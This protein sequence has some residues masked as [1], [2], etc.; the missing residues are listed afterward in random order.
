MPL[1]VYFATFLP[2]FFYA[3]KPVNP[4]HIIEYQGYI[5]KLQQSVVKHH[6]YQS[7]WWQWVI[8][9]RSIWFLYENVDGAQRG[10]VMLGNPLA[11]WAGLP[12]VLWCLWAGIW[13]KRRDA[14]AAAL[15][16]LVSIGMW[17][18]NGKPI[19]FYY[20][21]LL[22]GAFLMACLALA[23]DSLW[24]RTDRWRWTAPA[25]LIVALGLFVY[26]FPILSAAKLCCGKKSFEWWMWLRS[27]R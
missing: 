15:F 6:P 12:A 7:L 25:A 11:M 2:T 8:D 14:L 22:P 17:I 24:R 23:L 26:F 19:Q 27:W 21:Y 9:Q 3:E 5:L 16:Y 13:R 18:S 20:H 1:L 10:V 4:L